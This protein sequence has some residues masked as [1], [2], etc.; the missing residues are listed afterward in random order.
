MKCPSTTYNAGEELNSDPI[1]ETDMAD[2]VFQPYYRY[3]DQGGNFVYVNIMERN[4]QS[5]A[6]KQF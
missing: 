3:T 2:I 4:L 5:L 6:R 1:S